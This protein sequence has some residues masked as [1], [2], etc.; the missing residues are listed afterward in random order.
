MM[1]DLDLWALAFLDAGDQVIQQANNEVRP[2]VRR[3][4]LLHFVLHCLCAFDQVPYCISH[5]V[6]DLADGF[7]RTVV[8]HALLT[9]PES[10]ELAGERALS[11]SLAAWH[12]LGGQWHLWCLEADRQPGQWPQWFPS[13]K[14]SCTIRWSYVGLPW[15]HTGSSDPSRSDIFQLYLPGFS[16][17]WH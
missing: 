9:A 16:E 6:L 14:A 12:S 11:V 1:Y 15:L 17:E 4:E 13:Q 3:W 7:C 10:L 2:L 8:W 5:L